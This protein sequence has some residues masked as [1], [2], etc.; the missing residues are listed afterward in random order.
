[1]R[2]CVICLLMVSFL[3]FSA[4]AL[5]FSAPP[6]PNDA[7]Q[8]MPQEQET[9]G[10]GL[11][12]ILKT[13]LF[14]LRPNLAE[15]SGTCFSVIAAV[16]L[17]RIV[18]DFSSETNLSIRVVG[19]V[20]IGILLL[21]PIRSMVQLGTQTLTSVTE[22][23]KLLLPVMTAAEM[24]TPANRGSKGSTFQRPNSSTTA[25][26]VMT[27]AMAAQGGTTSSAALYAGTILFDTIL[28]TV[29]SRLIVPALYIFLC[30]CVAGSA[31][32]I[33]ILKKIRDFIKRKRR[34]KS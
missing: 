30:M 8:Y 17:I 26:P 23:G 31:L 24:A 20:V 5:D 34:P 32:E 15:A 7:E 28:T 16:L 2:K 14:R 11:W 3:V 19:A 1:M 18:S 25:G 9:F 27:A 10:E 12:Y 13:A 29:I 22:Y 6:V 21:Q 33:D 4:S